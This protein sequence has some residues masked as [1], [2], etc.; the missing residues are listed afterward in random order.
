MLTTPRKEER[1]AGQKESHGSSFTRH[2]APR[3][4]SREVNRRDKGVE[5]KRRER[6]KAT[7]PVPEAESGV[8]GPCLIRY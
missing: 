5:L 6:E 1:D 8:V 4:D 7:L 3:P 2:L